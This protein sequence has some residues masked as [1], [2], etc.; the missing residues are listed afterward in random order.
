[1]S[2]RLFL[3]IMIG[4]C[5]ATAQK[6]D[7]PKPPKPDLP[8]IKHADT[9]LA[10]EAVEAKVQKKKDDTLYTVDGANSPAKTPLAAPI[11]LFQSG[12]INPENLQLFRMES[13]DGHR[14][15]NLQKSGE[16]IRI[17]V[18][19]LGDTL[20]RIEPYNGLDPGEYALVAG[21]SNQMF[22]FAVF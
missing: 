2:L 4:T 19:K 8:Y 11:L 5:A 15:L 9:L 13:K 3:T 7:G 14:E 22:C 17:E 12:K 10:T 20:S 16:P 18:T 21:G 6:Y 1:M